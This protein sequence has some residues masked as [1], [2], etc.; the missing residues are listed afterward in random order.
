M[1]MQ[2]FQQEKCQLSVS[3]IMI[4]SILL[5]LNGEK[6]NQSEPVESA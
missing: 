4:L 1:H 5:M 2:M 3:C 6:R